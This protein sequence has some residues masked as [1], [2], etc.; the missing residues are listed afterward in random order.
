[1]IHRC[2]WA[3]LASVLVAQPSGLQALLKAYPEQLASA[4]ANVLLWWDGTRMTYDD[5]R[6]ANDPEAR[7]EHPSLYFQM[8]EPYPR[9]EAGVPPPLGT[10]PGRVR[11]EPF[12]RRLYGATPQDV[13]RNLVT[14]P[15][16]GR[17][18]L[19]VTRINGVDQR[20]RAISEELQRLPPHL[21]RCAEHPS[22]AYNPRPIAGTTR[23]SAHTYGIAIDLATAHADYWR[24]S[25]TATG[26]LPPYRNRIPL[27]VV[28]IFEQ[29]DFIWGGKWSHFDTMHFEYRPELLGE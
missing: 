26:T 15:W 16:L 6:R 27:E 5:G 12:F 21:R 18:T 4:E 24:W 7:L 19:R 22:G 23:P 10:D 28:R 11:F 9:G 25:R 8:M 13:E 20:L 29:H 17:W 2:W 14:I 1:M 3:L